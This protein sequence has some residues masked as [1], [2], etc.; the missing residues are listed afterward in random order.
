[1]TLTIVHT[2]GDDEL[3]RV[4]VAQT[5]D[6]SL[7]EFVESVQPPLPREQKWV[8]IVSTL[9]G[10]PV[11]C[12]ICDAGGN[13]AGR[14]TADEIMA[15]I[16][17]LVGR[18]F[19]DRRVPVPLFK[20]QFARMGEPAFNPAVIEVLDRLPDRLVAPGL[21]PSISTVAPKGCLAFLREL[22]VVKDRRYSGGRFQMQFSI[23]TTCDTRRRELIPAATLP[24]RAIA[25]EGNRFFSAGDRKIT[26][27]FAAVAGYPVD[28]GEVKSLFDPERFIIK[29]TP[30][31]PT[32]AA[33]SNGREGMIQ[34][35]DD[36]SAC[37]MAE[38]FRS[39]GFDTIVSIG[40]L[41]ENRIGSNCGMYVA[42][43]R[44]AG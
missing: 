28:A 18:R 9:K 31:N 36:P 12:P 22:K 29:L 27:N 15:Q 4:F 5:A 41:E 34:P 39:A 1:L 10:C 23:H 19:A 26:L 32:R 43:I 20:I 2:C 21:M 35:G 16:D 38:A 13:Y 44:A 40:E 42:T 6:G 33:L 24:L 11:R 30:V 17:H 8:L 25:Q 7:I 3:A 14:L 37:P